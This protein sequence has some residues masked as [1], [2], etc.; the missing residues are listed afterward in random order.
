MVDEELPTSPARITCHFFFYAENEQDSRANT[1]ICACLHQLFDQSPELLDFAMATFPK[2]E[3][4]ISTQFALLWDILVACAAE[5]DGEVLCVLDS[6]HECYDRSDDSFR[7][8]KMGKDSITRSDLI[9]KLR[10]YYGS[11]EKK[12]IERGRLKFLIST[13]PDLDGL[14]KLEEVSFSKTSIQLDN[15]GDM[16]IVIDAKVN[17][18]SLYD[19]EKDFLKRELKKFNQDSQTFLWLDL[20]INE[21]SSKLRYLHAPEDELTKFLSKMPKSVHQA[22][23][24]ILK[25]IDEDDVE[26]ARMVFHIILAAQ[27]PLTVGELN[28][29]VSLA[30]TRDEVRKITNLQPHDDF[31]KRLSSEFHGFITVIQ[32]QVYFLHPTATE[33]LLPEPETKASLINRTEWEHTFWP[34]VSNALLAKVC[35]A[36]LKLERPSL[37]PTPHSDLWD[38]ASD[39]CAQTPFMDYAA[40]YLLLHSVWSDIKDSVIVDTDENV[41]RA[42]EIGVMLISLFDISLEGFWNWFI[43]LWRYYGDRLPLVELF[44][45]RVELAASRWDMDNSVLDALPDDIREASSEAMK[46]GKAEAMETEKES[47][48]L[49]LTASR[50]S[51]VAKAKMQGFIA[52]DM[53]SQQKS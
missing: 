19:P 38:I 29:A 39:Y 45:A 28:I 9:N 31:R 20:I 40:P 15:R 12:S 8:S 33:F 52:L 25:R 51:D 24:N 5:F 3:A 18:L 14:V 49:V 37:S 30:V 2:T 35:I 11:H 48:R 22:Y 17:A 21:L 23:C 10:E 42:A 13:R 43:C 4:N 46:M 50:G 1:A 41:P 47:P 32:D 36:F 27:R 34:D 53:L 7:S 16:D 26:R 44:K 6:L